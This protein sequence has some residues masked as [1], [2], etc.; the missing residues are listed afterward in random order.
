VIELVTSTR[1][2]KALS[3]LKG[4]FI[5]VPS[6]ALSVDQARRLTR[7]DET[8]CLALLLALEQAHFLRR[9]RAGQFLLRSDPIGMD[10]EER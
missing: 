8:T 6:T 1:V 2:D 4:L 3:R 9:S 5:E 10:R 7:L